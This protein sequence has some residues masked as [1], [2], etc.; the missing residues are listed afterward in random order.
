MLFAFAEWGQFWRGYTVLAMCDNMVVVNAINAKSVRG[1]SID[2]LQLIFL[3]AALYDIE[4]SIQWLSSKDNWIADALSRFE[5]H[6]V[7]D[8]FPQFYRTGNSQFHPHQTSGKPMSALREKLQIFFGTDSLPTLAKSTMS[9][10]LPTSDLP[11]SMDSPLPFLYS[12]KRSLSSSLQ[13]PKK[14]QRKRK[15]VC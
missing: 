2:P 1:K 14:R 9:E 8:I 12:S 6:K 13:Q 15:N 4:V 7:A 5:I 11:R 10:K 3:T